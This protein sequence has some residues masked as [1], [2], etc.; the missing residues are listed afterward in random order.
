MAQWGRMQGEGR[1]GES[2]VWKGKSGL[3]NSGEKVGV[4]K[5][6]GESWMRWGWRE[7][8]VWCREGE[9]GLR[10]W[11]MAAQEVAVATQGRRRR[12]RSGGDGAR[13][14]TSTESTTT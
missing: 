8:L 9:R 1:D 12:F 4:E 7:I 10:R 14:T 6:L 5:E 2:G 11:M 13:A 3:Q